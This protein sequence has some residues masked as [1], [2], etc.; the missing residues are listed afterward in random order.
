MPSFLDGHAK[1]FWELLAR[2]LHALGLLYQVDAGAFGAVCSAY[3]TWRTAAE[4]LQERVKQHGPLAGLVDVTT[5]G[6]VIQNPLVGIMNK[7]RRD[8]VKFCSEFG[9]TP[10]A[11]AGLAIDPGKAKKGKFDGLLNGPGMKK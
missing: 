2:G 4:L 8:Y 11:R 9:M 10:S 6:N 5:A 3:S 7:A 1:E